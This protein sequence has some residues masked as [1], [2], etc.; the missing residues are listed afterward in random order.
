MFLHFWFDVGF[1]LL[2][3]YFVLILFL[4]CFL[5]CFQTMKKHNFPAILVFCHVVLKVVYCYS[6]S[7]FCCCL[8]FLCCL[9]PV[10]TLK[11]HH[12]VSV[13]SFFCNMT[14]WF[15][16]LHLVVLLPF[17]FLVFI[18]FDVFCVFHSSPRKTPP[19]TDTAKTPKINMQKKRTKN[20]SVSAVVFT[21]SV[22]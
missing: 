6:V 19:K 21:N 22:P 10:L 15:S 18:V 3:F 5:V 14:K 9:F 17:C 16:C 8:S 13:L 2:C 4:F 20:N 11:L 7:Y 12:F 1:V